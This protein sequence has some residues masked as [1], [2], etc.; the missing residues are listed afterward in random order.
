MKETHK[1]LQPVLKL[2]IL[3]MT[4]LDFCGASVHFGAFTGKLLRSTEKQSCLMPSTTKLASRA[5]I[6]RSKSM[7]LL[8]AMF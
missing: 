8:L 5:T 6:K 3:S 1:R 2:Y 7:T 4:Q